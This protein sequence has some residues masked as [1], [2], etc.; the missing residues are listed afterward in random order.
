MSMPHSTLGWTNLM[1]SG[2]H[3]Q[4]GYDACYL[5]AWRAYLTGDGLGSVPPPPQG[6]IVI[7]PPLSFLTSFEMT[8]HRGKVRSGGLYTVTGALEKKGVI[9]QLTDG[10]LDHPD[11]LNAYFW[12]RKLDDPG[13]HA[14]LTEEV[15]VRLD[16]LLDRG[17]A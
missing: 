13:I 11:D 16:Q 7:V 17:L 12:P 1:S 8:D 15:R 14:A 6:L 9:F 10:G 3:T 5:H 4:M 2:W